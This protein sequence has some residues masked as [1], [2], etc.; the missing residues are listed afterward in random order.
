MKIRRTKSTRVRTAAGLALV[1]LAATAC[2]STVAPTDRVALAPGQPG[3]GLATDGGSELGAPAGG[4]ADPAA[5]GA[6]G[7]DGSTGV[8]GEPAPG[9][10]AADSGSV[11]GAGT[12]G[13]PGTGTSKAGGSTAPKAG[14]PAT[15]GRPPSK[16]RGV[17]DTTVSIGF[18]YTQN[19]SQA[20][21][22]VG[23]QGITSG[24]GLKNAK[25][26]I[27]EL[28][29]T[30]GLAGREIKP[31]FHAFDATSSDS[32]ESQESAACAD[33]T[34]DRPVFA[35]ISTSGHDENY[36]TCLGKAGIAN[37]AAPGL[38]VSDATVLKR[39]PLYRELNSV[40]L[41]RQGN[42]YGAPLAASGYFGQGAKVGV[43]TLDQSAFKREYANN[44]VPA[45]KQAGATLTDTVVV[46]F[47][48]GSGDVGA[49]SSAVSSAVLRFRQKGVTH[50]LIA[51]SA[52]LA[53]ILFL[54]AAANQNYLP[55]YGFNSQNGGQAIVASVSDKRSLK[56]AVQLGWAPSIDLDA[57]N[58]TTAPPGKK[59][60]L[61]LF[62]SK[63]V[64][65]D[66][67]NAEGI[68]LNECD[69][70]FFAQAAGQRVQQ[71]TASSF[72][73]A[74]AGIGGAVKSASTYA[75]NLQNGRGGAT[76]YRL[77]R[78]NEGCTCFKAE[79]GVKALG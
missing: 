71:L 59:R 50:V 38:T 1:A 35:V 33:F 23:A 55:R 15:K 9:G 36:L 49:L 64:V 58:E 77:Q 3:D 39:N 40:D 46:P 48:R 29:R 53:T 14:A 20:N 5:G 57:A 30:G 66:S 22:A 79:G 75:I 74:Y 54:N 32:I 78:W 37:V 8:A 52:G 18:E 72:V 68:L 44:V 76:G 67:R 60:C 10:G 21:S 65:A 4:Q 28:N 62:R 34:T 41:G 17:T 31:V 47:Y 56:G 7:P 51:D 42:L 45:I 26:L 61:D 73:Q 16:A 6:A 12:P 13:K 25:I 19:S 70:Y 2:G 24:D 43:L 11:P 27:A 69:T 63:G